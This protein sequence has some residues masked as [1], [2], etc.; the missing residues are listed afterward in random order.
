MVSW[1]SYSVILETSAIRH[2]V[3]VNEE[4]NNTSQKAKIR[5]HELIQ[6][7][8]SIELGDKLQWNF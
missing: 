8:W 3:S 5:L 4:E 7:S 6:G 2:D 1:H